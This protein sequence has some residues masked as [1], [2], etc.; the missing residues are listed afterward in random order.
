M[1]Q[2][3]EKYEGRGDQKG[4][5]FTLV[6]SWGTVALYSKEKHGDMTYEVVRVRKRKKD[7]YVGEKQIA[8]TGD[9]YLPSSREWGV[10]GWTY[11]VIEKAMERIDEL[12]KRDE[13]KTT[14][15]NDENN[16]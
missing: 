8:S 2:I 15:E 12:L 1:K 7:V 5:T 4:Y 11:N 3:P 13:S 10:Y 14:G 6:R 16:D 9:E